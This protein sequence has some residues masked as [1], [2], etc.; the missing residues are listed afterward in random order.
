MSEPPAVAFAR[1]RPIALSLSGGGYRAAAFHLGVLAYLERQQLLSSVR[2]LSTVSGGTF[3]GAA[4]VLA[5]VEGLAFGDFLRRYYAA[6]R[7]TDL[8]RSGLAR[9]GRGPADVPSRRRD[10]IVS[11]ADVYARTLFRRADGQPW[12]FGAILDSQAGPEEVVFNATEFR[13][14]VAFRF[15]RSRRGLIGNGNVHIPREA[16][17]LLRVADVVAASSCFPGGFEPL[18]FPGDF[19]W[20][21]GQVPAAAKALGSVALMDGGIYDNQGIQALLLAEDRAPIELGLFIVSDTDRLE[22]NLYTFPTRQAEGGLSV[23]VLSRLAWAL[24]VLCALSFG[25]S[26]WGLR[27]AFAWRPELVLTH[28]IPMLLAG[29]TAFG[30]WWLR[31][32]VRALLERVPQ[33]GFTAWSDLRRLPFDGLLDLVQLRVGSLLALTSSVFMRRIRALVYGEVYGNP[34]YELSRVSNLVYH[35]RSGER[36]TPLPGVPAPSTRLRAVADTASGMPTTLWFDAGEPWRQP[37]LVACGQATLCYNLMKRLVRSHPGSPPEA[38]PVEA[39][40][41]WDRLVAD[42]QRLNADPYALLR[43]DLPGQQLPTPPHWD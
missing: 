4:W 42:W 17:A 41:L 33:V 12:L 9:L 6:L 3:T 5:C 39:R 7:D 38:W 11:M 35:L 36:F 25:V 27:R 16:A 22:P 14:G 28:V 8:L 15:Q 24:M 26:L 21:G 23:G 1:A 34:R 29:A 18:D 40:E 13:T 19:V 37:S 32:S 30:L 10:L 31:R 20:P 2:R 43:E